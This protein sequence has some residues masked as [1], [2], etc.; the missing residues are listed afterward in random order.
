MQL[1]MTRPALQMNRLR[2]RASG[3]RPALPNCAPGRDQAEGIT[4][5]ASVTVA[6]GLRAKREVVGDDDVMLRHLIAKRSQQ[7]REAG[8]DDL[9]RQRTQRRNAAPAGREDF[10]MLAQQIAARRLVGRDKRQ[11]GLRGVLAPLG[12]AD[13]RHLVPTGDETAAEREKRMKVAARAPRTQQ[14]A[15]GVSAPPAAAA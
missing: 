9:A 8:G 4:P 15:H 5:G 6:H 13:Q 2:A 14:P 3:P 7:R 1:V 11:A 12:M 10:G